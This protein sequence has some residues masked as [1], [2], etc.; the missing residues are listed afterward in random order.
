MVKFLVDFL[1]FS[2]FSSLKTD[3]GLSIGAIDYNTRAVFLNALVTVL[4][5]KHGRIYRHFLSA[6]WSIFWSIFLILQISQ[7]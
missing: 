2:D 6:W 7:V 1:D 3:F 4:V 5:V